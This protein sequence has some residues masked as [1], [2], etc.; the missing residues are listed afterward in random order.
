MCERPTFQTGSGLELTGGLTYAGRVALE[1]KGHHATG[2]FLVFGIVSC[3]FCHL[4][5]FPPSPFF[6]T[7]VKNKTQSL[8][9]TIVGHMLDFLSALR[10]LC[11]L[12]SY[13]ERLCVWAGTSRHCARCN[14]STF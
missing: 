14:H 5:G 13:L 1:A 9:K 12:C 6:I 7:S 10:Q 8:N 11:V 3:L 4:C 2:A